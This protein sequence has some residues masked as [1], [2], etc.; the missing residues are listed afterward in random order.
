MRMLQM[1]EIKDGMCPAKVLF[2]QFKPE[3]NKNF[4]FAE[5]DNGDHVYFND[6]ARV[7]PVFNGGDEPQWMGWAKPRQPQK[8][9]M[10]LIQTRTGPKGKFAATWA[11]KDEY[12]D[13]MSQI[14]RRPVYR[15]IQQNGPKRMGRLLPHGWESPKVRWEGKDISILRKLFRKD[16]YPCVD[17]EHWRAWFEVRI[18]N[19]WVTTDDPR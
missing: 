19:A 1:M 17:T 4:G 14:S 3:D 11:F 9:E 5:L 16:S 6:R 2:F 13:V 15:L 7:Q 8:G 12:D 18:G 10:I